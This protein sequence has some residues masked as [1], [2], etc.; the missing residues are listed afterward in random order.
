MSATEMMDLEERHALQG[1]GI[2]GGDG[3]GCFC[4]MY[5]FIDCEKWC[6]EVV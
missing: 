4:V 2:G 1:K 3:Y 6:C 5:K